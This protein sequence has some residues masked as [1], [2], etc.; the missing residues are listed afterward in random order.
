M[1]KTNKG[2]IALSLATAVLAGP[3]PAQDCTPAHEFSTIEEG[4]ITVAPSNYP[5]YAYVDSDGELQGID[6]DILKAIAKLECLEVKAIPVDAAAALQYVISG[7]ADLSAGDYY[8]TEKRQRVTNLSDPLYLDQMAVYSKAGVSNIDDM[9][10]Q[11][12]GS[13]QGNLWIEDAKKVFGENLKIYPVAPAALKDLENG[14]IDIVLDGYSVGLLAQQKG[15]M[16]GITIKVIEPDP[17]ISASMGAAQGAFPINKQNT[18]L[19]EAI[20]ADIATLKEDGTLVK[21]LESYGLDASAAD[22]GEPR[23]IK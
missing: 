22:T 20:N 9:I 6:G 5:P 19:L 3:A 21:I 10:G 23:L 16:Q 17:R 2:M 1:F 7:K 15:A 18:G 13:T 12:V 4:A 14:R 11:P 8:R